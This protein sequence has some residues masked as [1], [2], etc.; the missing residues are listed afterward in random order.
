M[1]I[2]NTDMYVA[3]V[4]VIHGQSREFG[5]Q[6]RYGV[7]KHGLDRIVLFETRHGFRQELMTY[8]V[9]VLGIL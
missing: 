6:S 9:I 5:A 3:L 2:I 4:V 1:I 8:P 7:D